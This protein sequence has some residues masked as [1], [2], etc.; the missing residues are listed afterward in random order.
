MLA[1]SY[2]DL[3]EDLISELMTDAYQG[4]VPLFQNRNKETER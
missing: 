2:L 1:T 3:G 4:F